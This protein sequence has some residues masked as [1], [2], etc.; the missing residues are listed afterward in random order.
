MIRQLQTDPALEQHLY[1]TRPQQLEQLRRFAKAPFFSTTFFD[2][3]INALAG[4]EHIKLLNC[5]NRS[6]KTFVGLFEDVADCLLLDPLTMGPSWKFDEPISMWIITNTEDTAIRLEELLVR[7]I[8]GTDQSGA[9]W[10]F[11]SDKSSYSEQSGFA[12]HQ[13]LFTNNS[14]I[15]VK[16]STQK[17]ETFQMVS[18]HKVHMDEEQP[19]SIYEESRTRL[20]DKDGYFLLTFTPVYDKKRGVSWAYKELYQPRLAKGVGCYQ[21]SMLDNPYLPEA[22]KK[23]LIEEMDED[24]K[25]VRVHGRFVPAGVSL[26]FGNKL[27]RQLEEKRELTH[28]TPY[29]GF[30]V[31]SEDPRGK[32]RFIIQEAED[33]PG[34]YL[35]HDPV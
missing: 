1:E 19:Q 4:R 5:G 15:E 16:Y 31:P 20:V 12:N 24:D 30:F 25:E 27:Q 14:R 13:I 23:R 17:R 26:A 9:M 22:A 34:E 10:N 18:L 33:A 32:P 35:T 7:Y 6:G 28:F 29:D 3:Q 21:W 2:K 11:I 8:L